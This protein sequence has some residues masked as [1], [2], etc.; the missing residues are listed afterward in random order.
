MRPLFAIRNDFAAVAELLTERDGDITEPEVESAVT[1]WFAELGN[2]LGD[3]LDSIHHYL[4]ERKMRLEACKQQA[5][6]WE[7]RAKR[8]AR[9]IDG[10]KAHVLEAVQQLGGKVAS[11]KGVIFT[12]RANGGKAPL[13]F[14]DGFVCPEA[15]Q[16][17]K[18]VTDTDAIRAEL[19]SDGII[20]GVTI[21]ERGHH[22]RVS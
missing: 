13:V 20:P 4:S 3:K 1:A 14:D 5:S 11:A 19:E 2:E 17:V 9:A 7:A 21:G 16:A 12:A 22:L 6:E 15:Y 18:Y 10:I 8:E